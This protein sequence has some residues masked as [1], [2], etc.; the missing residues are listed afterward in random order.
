MNQR[1]IFD[2]FRLLV[3]IIMITFAPAANAITM[4]FHITPLVGTAPLT[5]QWTT[6]VTLESDGSAWTAIKD[7]G[8]SNGV[9][10]YTDKVSLTFNNAGTYSYTFTNI[11]L[12]AGD[13][14]CW[15]DI[16]GNDPS[17]NSWFYE[18]GPVNVS[19]SGGGGG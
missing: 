12:P 2:L 18:I 3:P 8:V 7:K 1:R 13:W 6:T 19:S 11:V 4:S 15:S 5:T 10:N 16:W 17:N 14:S 9:W